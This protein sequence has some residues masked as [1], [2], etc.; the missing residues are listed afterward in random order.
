MFPPIP[1][2]MS[3]MSMSLAGQDYQ[4]VVDAIREIVGQHHAAIARVSA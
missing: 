1:R 3:Y 4:P 2:R